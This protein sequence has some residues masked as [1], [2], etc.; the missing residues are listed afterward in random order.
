MHF[1]PGEA[2]L[3]RLRDA[4]AL[5]WPSLWTPGGELKRDRLPGRYRLASLTIGDP[6]G[7]CIAAAS[8]D[9]AGLELF[10]IDV[11][12][13][14]R[15]GDPTFEARWC[16]RRAEM[17]LGGPLNALMPAGRRAWVVTR[18]VRV[19]EGGNALDVTCDQG[20]LFESRLGRRALI[21]ADDEHPL[22]L[23]VATSPQDIARYLDAATVLRAVG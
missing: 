21:W 22:D 3:A 12:S 15:L 16:P 23:L 19:G 10:G 9:I 8:H 4:L 5:P 13:D 6:L 2:S 14:D 7:L 17:R 11:T 20:L 18:T 1:G